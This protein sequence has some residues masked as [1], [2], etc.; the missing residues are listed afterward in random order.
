MLKS[1]LINSEILL[2]SPVMPINVRAGNE[3][4][5]HNLISWLKKKNSSCSIIIYNQEAEISADLSLQMDNQFADWWFITKSGQLFTSQREK[6]WELNQSRIESIYDRI[7]YSLVYGLTAGNQV[8]VYSNSHLRKLIR[9][10]LKSKS[11]SLVITNYCFSSPILD[12]FPKNETLKILDTHDVF[13]RKNKLHRNLYNDT[14]GISRHVE[15]K[16]L[17]KADVVIAIQENESLILRELLPKAKIVTCGVQLNDRKPFRLNNLSKVGYIA[18]NNLYNQVALKKY[19]ENVHP[20][21]MEKF[22]EYELVVA[23]SIVRSFPDG[24]AG[25]KF[26][27]EFD[28][29]NAIYQQVDLT[30]NPSTHGTGLKIKAIES[31]EQGRIYVSLPNGCEGLAS[32][33]RDVAYFETSN[34]YEMYVKIKY[35]IS[36]SGLATLEN[37]HV[38]IFK[39]FKKENAYGDLEKLLLLGLE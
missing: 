35:I 22:K 19:L 29:P 34:L 36:E 28:D 39:D 30:I 16:L 8:R 38:K 24:L 33:Y 37:P 31:L 17:E 5:V 3:Y 7:K 20:L 12:L 13:S 6:K 32:D 26:L 21:L 18:S 15:K 11:F 9:E 23:G 2:I 1:N 27:G 14:T 10:I 4:R 25:V